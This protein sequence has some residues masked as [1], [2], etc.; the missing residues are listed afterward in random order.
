MTVLSP[1]RQVTWQKGVG[2]VSGYAQT[3]IELKAVSAT[4][5]HVVEQI[6]FLMGTHTFAYLQFGPTA[7]SA[8]RLKICTNRSLTLDGLYLTRGAKHQVSVVGNSVTADGSADASGY[9]IAP[10]VSGGSVSKAGGL[11]DQ[12]LTGT[13]DFT[14][15]SANPTVV[16]FKAAHNLVT[17]DV[18]YVYNNTSTTL[19]DGKYVFTK[20]TANAGTVAADTTGAV[21]DDGNIY[22]P[23]PSAYQGQFCHIA[24]DATAAGTTVYTPL[25]R[26]PVGRSALIDHMHLIATAA[27]AAEDRAASI[28]LADAYTGAGSYNVEVWRGTT[29][30][31]FIKSNLWVSG[32]QSGGAN[33]TWVLLRHDDI[34]SLGGTAT[35]YVTG[36]MDPHGPPSVPYYSFISHTITGAAT[37]WS[38]SSVQVPAGKKAV[39]MSASMHYRPTTAVASTFSF[40]YSTAAG[41]TAFIPLMSCDSATP[42][43]EI[44]GPIVV[45]ASLVLESRGV[46]A[47]GA[48]ALGWTRFDYYLI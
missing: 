42:Y 48:D 29:V 19:A 35:A 6:R 13:T 43:A 32:N 44:T 37:T 34:G 8:S 17:G 5:A 36:Q 18:I 4:Q 23:R 25:M 10:T 31:S 20:T 41:G 1:E 39:I 24:N 28:Y 47:A 22:I 15:T 12:V 38:A 21:V 33:G 30:A 14:L 11:G 40:G 46:S 2:P 26:I 45:P 27:D 3:A 9:S 16:N 7:T